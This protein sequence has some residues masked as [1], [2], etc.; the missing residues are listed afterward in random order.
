MK[1]IERALDDKKVRADMNRWRAEW[2]VLVEK[3]EH[4]TALL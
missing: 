4:T 1:W 2:R 3:G